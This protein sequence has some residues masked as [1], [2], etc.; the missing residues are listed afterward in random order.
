MATVDYG[1]EVLTPIKIRKAACHN[2]TQP[3]Y[4]DDAGALGKFYNL[5]RYFNSL[6]ISAWCRGITLIPLKPF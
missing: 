5:V 2:V 1:V 4:D 3:C 6:N